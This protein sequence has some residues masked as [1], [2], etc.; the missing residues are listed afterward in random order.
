[1]VDFTF[2]KCNCETSD[3][4][5]CLFL[6]CTDD[7]CVYHRLI[8]KWRYRKNKLSELVKKVDGNKEDMDAFK[9]EVER[10]EKV[11]NM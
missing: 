1:M 3:C 7:S 4:G 6:G 8:T 11:L 2:K 10:L 9:N 5:K